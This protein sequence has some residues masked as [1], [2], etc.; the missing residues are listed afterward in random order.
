V[1]VCS[2]RSV[3]GECRQASSTRVTDPA[4]AASI[5]WSRAVVP[6][7]VRPVGGLIVEADGWSHL[8]GELRIRC[9]TTAEARVLLPAAWTGLPV[10]IADERGAGDDAA[11]DS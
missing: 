9:R 11:R 8:D 2:G 4:A 1:I 6:G 3:G 5:E 10:R 7:S